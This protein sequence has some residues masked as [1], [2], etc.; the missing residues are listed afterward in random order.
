[1]Q[2]F[3]GHIAQFLGDALL[4]YFGWP[5]AHED[6]VER[7]VRTGLGMLDAMGTFNTRLERERGIRLAIRVSIHTG[8]VVVGEMGGGGH[9]ERLALG[10]YAEYRVSSPRAGRTQHDRDERGRVSV[11]ARILRVPSVGSATPQRRCCSDALEQAFSRYRLPLAESVPLFA[12]LLSVTGFYTYP[13]HTLASQ[14]SIA[15][16]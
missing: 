12:S 13:E 7:A 4:I 16:P 6:D 1:V 15:K 9:Q 2:R 10:G 11:S 14:A 5:Q 3:D 8:L